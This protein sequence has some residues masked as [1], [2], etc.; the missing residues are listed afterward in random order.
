MAMALKAVHVCDVPN[1]DQVPENAALALCSTRFR[2]GVNDDKICECNIPKFL[3]VGHRGNGMNML[4]SPDPRMKSIKENSILSFNEAAKFPIDFIEF[5]VQVT[6]DDYPVIYHDNFILHEEK[7]AIVENRVTELALAEFLSYGP[8]KH[9]GSEGK[10]LYRKTKD[11]RF[12][13]WKVEK[14]APLCTLEEAFHNVD[15]SVGFNVE[16][17]FDD[18]IV[19]KEEELT[20]ILKAILKVVFENAKGRQIL[21]SSF[22]PD[23]A[24]LIRKLQS[25]YPVYFLTNGGSEIYTD[26]RRNSLEEAIKLSLENGLQGI[27]SEVKAVFRNPGAVGRIKESKLSLMTYGQLNNV[28]E[29]VYMQHLMGVE[30][31]IVDLVKEISE[32]VSDLTHSKE[33]EEKS[34]YGEEDG[35]K[36]VKAK[37]QFSKDELSFLLKLIPELMIQA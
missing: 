8:Q 32:S 20:R 6:K 18:F 28:P 30:G 31:V 35:K 34:L 24:R 36:E 15:Q 26:V 9:P 10:P 5:D 16:L 11:G 2:A 37:P 1:L 7:G 14:D 21:F 3:V 22:Q 4:Q 13:E 23:A 25:T 27:V 33:G 17:K 19:Y 12:F 29:V